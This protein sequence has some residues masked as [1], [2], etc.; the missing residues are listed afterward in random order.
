MDNRMSSYKYN[1]C[2]CLLN[3]CKNI[4]LTIYNK[5]NNIYINKYN[6]NNII[7]TFSYIL[8][9]N[10]SNIKINFHNNYYLYDKKTILNYNNN[11]DNIINNDINNVLNN[12]KIL[13]KNNL[14]IKQ[15]L[16]N[17]IYN[18]NKKLNINYI[19]QK[20]NNMYKYNKE[21]T[22]DT[23]NKYINYVYDNNLNVI[24]LV[25]I[26]PSYINN[27]QIKGGNIL[28]N[29]VIDNYNLFVN[30]IENKYIIGKNNY[31]NYINQ[32]I[33]NY[34]DLKN[35]F[36]SYDN[37]DHTE[38]LFII[39]NSN[40]KIIIYYTYLM[41]FNYKLSDYDFNN[42]NPNN[43]NQNDIINYRIDCIC[44][45]LEDIIDRNFNFSNIL[46]IIYH[47]GI[48]LSDNNDM[49]NYKLIYL[50]YN[51]IN[52]INENNIENN[53]NL[54]NKLIYKLKIFNKQN[55]NDIKF[56]LNNMYN[57]YDDKFDDDNFKL[58]YIS[59]LN[60]YAL[61]YIYSFD[62]YDSLTKSNQEIDVNALISDLK[63]EIKLFLEL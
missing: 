45:G 27:E 32:C 6:N 12:Y 21:L 24:G 19:L 52:N 14:F 44:Y 10:I 40:Y 58:N 36:S 30:N 39:S 54:I 49:I 60:I 38:E 48:N 43:I 23:K 61:Y 20:Y 29:E 15:E 46:N 5:D 9:N 8:N 51:I 22:F 59:Q 50:C 41:F 2:K 35:I 55:N 25:K 63:Y 13:N 47:C 17:N 28:L 34:I 16:L 57:K 4:Y 7:Y 37:V 53:I 56:V 31:K 1:E 3:N 11:I 33:L 62:F 42:Y 18:I 26:N